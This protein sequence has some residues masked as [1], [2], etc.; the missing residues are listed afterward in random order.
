MWIV[1]R[2]EARRR[3]LDFS[4]AGLGRHSTTSLLAD[5]IEI[6]NALDLL[7][8]DEDP[9]EPLQVL[10]CEQCGM[11]GCRSGNRVAF[12]NFDDGLLLI[13]AFAAMAPGVWE[14]DEYGPPPFLLERG[15]L[16]FRGSSLESLAFHLPVAGD[17][18]RWPALGSREAAFLLQAQAPARALGTFPATPSLPRERF[19]ATPSGSGDAVVLA[20]ND[21]LARA[22]ERDLPV[23]TLSGGAEPLHLDQAGYPDWSPLVRQEDEYHLA[24]APG[25]GIR[26]GQGSAE[27]PGKVRVTVRNSRV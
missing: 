24:L 8:V 2:V 12:R 13:P 27:P 7:D 26:W 18:A 14:R 23:S 15:A 22:F 25:L 10:V 4:S 3:E 1:R 21:L 16:W 5:G 9:R 11:E 6:V 20:L 19:A 17:L